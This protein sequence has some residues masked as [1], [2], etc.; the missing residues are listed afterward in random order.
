MLGPRWVL[1]G[2]TPN[3]GKVKCFIESTR[4]QSPGCPEHGI[5]GQWSMAGSFPRLTAGGG[6][7]RRVGRG[8]VVKAEETWDQ[9]DVQKN[10]L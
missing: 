10:P 8:P 6:K 4:S 2:D 9:D 7:G 1:H 5:V 3:A